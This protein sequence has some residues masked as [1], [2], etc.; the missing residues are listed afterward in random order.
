MASGHAT[1][2]AVLSGDTL[3]LMGAAAN[4]PPQELML[5]LS[6]LQAPRLARSPEQSNEPYAWASREHLRKLCIG[7]QVRFKVE[8]RVPSIN[9]DFGSVWLPP[10]ARNVEE[11][12]C[13]IQ[14]RTG[15]ARVKTL[16]QSREGVCVDH[17]KMLQ[18][19]QVAI[20]EK[21]GMYADANA[22]S[23]VTVQWHGADAAALLEAHKGKLVPAIVESVR[24]GASFRVILKPSLQLVNFALSGVQCPRM[25]PPM[26]AESNTSVTTGP[27]PHAREAKHF[28]EVRLLHR[29]VELKLEGVDK[30]GNLFGSIVH[31]SGRNISVELLKNGLG[32]MADWSSAFTSASARAT[33]RNAEKEAKQQQLRVWRDYELPVLQSVKHVTGT[34]VEVISGDCI[35]VYV[36]TAPTPIEQEKR[37]YLSSLRAPRLGN[38]RRGEM[39][40]PY[41]IEAKEFI[42]HRAIAKTVHIEVEY[43]KPSPNGQGDIMTFASVFLEPSANALKKNPEA[44]GAN[45]A[46]EIVAAGLAEVVRHR[47]DEEKSEYYDDLV[48]AETK[49]QSQKKNLHSTKEPPT[50]ERRVTDLCFDSTKAKQFLPFLTRERST[51]AVVEHV[52]SATRVKLYV[53]K[54]NCLI[55]FVVAGIKCPQPARHGAQGVI[56]QPAES[57]GEEAKLFTKRNVMQREVMVEIE[58]MDRG[59]NAFGPLF[60]VPQDGGKPSR[61]DAHNF[62]VRLL[63]EG[64]AWVDSFS[65]E[66]TAFGNVLQRAE[67]RAKAQK[68]NYWATHDALAAAKAAEAK[69]VKTKDDVIPR[70]KLSEIVNGTHFYF[71]NISDRNCAAIEEKMKAFTRTHGLAGKTFEVRRNAVCAALF[72]D[73]NGSTWNRTKVEH[74][75]QDGSARVRFLDYGNETTVTVNQLRPL[76]ADALQYPPQAKEAVF[77]WIK[78]LA[79]TEEFGADAAMRLGE[80]A[81]GKTLS[82]R[83]HNVD[84]H[85]RKQVS[86]Y[87]PDGKSVAESL[88]E[89]GLLRIDR[90]AL[91]LCLP[92][93]KPV[94]DGLLNAQEI[95]KK[96]RRCLWQY[97]DIESD[98]EQDP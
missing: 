29:D 56:V 13:V 97:G 8:Y 95:A 16:E 48:T 61:D 20:N 94:V 76:D 82:C 68:K 41:A 52:Y 86:L 67:E 32:R 60:V 9:R 26:N 96:Q 38:A 92:F 33:M 43:E 73:G 59:G 42:R 55:N 12:L 40:A 53:P 87:L 14:A 81:W 77:A 21:K 4:G 2:K 91:R 17:E 69:Q 50:T 51:R 24:D 65:V 54:E 88:V 28:S 93:Q 90:K 89:A 5:T 25:N 79:A 83:V 98:D 71:Q 10:N 78:P 64:L 85:G 3:V 75:N 35:V 7:K 62:G 19:E 34:V 11:N 30:F 22:E 58:D 39:N 36:P 44:K 70:V 23:N 31:P 49:A 74:V 37:I 80:V 1:V 84:D 45:L 46:L 6:S 66:R 63:D 57:L 27:A 47:P 72:D 15:Y 18:Q